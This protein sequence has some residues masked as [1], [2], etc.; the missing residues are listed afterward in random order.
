MELSAGRLAKLAL[1]DE[2]R[3]AVDEARRLTSHGARRRQIAYIGRIMEECD[4]EALR[5]SL[6]AI[7]QPAASHPATERA[8]IRE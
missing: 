4:E 6:A 2:L 5:A 7:D 8:T 1:S 3:R